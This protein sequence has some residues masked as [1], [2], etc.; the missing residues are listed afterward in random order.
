[1]KELV[2]NRRGHIDGRNLLSYWSFAKWFVDSAL[3]IVGGGVL[4]NM[5]AVQVWSLVFV[6]W[7]W[8]FFKEL[9][10]TP[11]VLIWL[12]GRIGY[13]RRHKMAKRNRRR[14]ARRSR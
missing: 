3:V 10:D 14:K 9:L 8:T 11:L 5:P 1:M 4:L 7:V 12:V 13:H 2:V 6:L